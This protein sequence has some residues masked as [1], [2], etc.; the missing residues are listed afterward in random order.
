[1]KSTPMNPAIAATQPT[2][3]I[4]LMQD[5]TRHYHNQYGPEE[6]Y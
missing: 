6:N 2:M 4:F 1:M 5:R 3:P